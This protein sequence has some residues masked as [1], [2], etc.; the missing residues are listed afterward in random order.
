MVKN[1][2]HENLFDFVPFELRDFGPNDK[3]VL[4]KILGSGKSD[5]IDAYPYHHILLINDVEPLPIITKASFDRIDPEVINIVSFKQSLKECENLS[6]LEVLF[7]IKVYEKQSFINRVVTKNNFEPIPEIYA[8]LSGS[9]GFLAFAHQLEQLY[10]MLT[11]KNYLESISFRKD[12][13]LKRPK[14]RKVAESIFVKPG[15][16]LADILQVR[17][18]EQNQ[19]L[20]NANF[21][22]AYQLWSYLNKIKM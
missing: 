21:S 9:F 8:L 22:G 3:A 16:S 12:W 1:R 10:C 4:M 11:G 18:L 20:Y 17:C 7:F 6:F 5:Y 19:F 2:L 13:N 15:L 14:V